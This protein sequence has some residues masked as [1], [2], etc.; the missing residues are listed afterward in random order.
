MI[1]AWSCI[2]ALC[3]D[4]VLETSKLLERTTFCQA[5][6]WRRCV[7]TSQ[8][9]TDFVGHHLNGWSDQ[10]ETGRRKGNFYSWTHLSPESTKPS[11]IFQRCV[12]VFFG[13]SMTHLWTVSFLQDVCLRSLWR[14][15]GLPPFEYLISFVFVIIP[16]S[17][18][19]Q[20][21]PVENLLSNWMTLWSRC[22]L[23]WN[24]VKL[25]VNIC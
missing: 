11:N 2:N 16:L 18:K 25:C 15:S 24:Y 7:A 3:D 17:F 19:S 13:K 22:N 6:R 10:G 9:R 1:D 21:H 4:H 12:W 20:S 8:L 14:C 5:W 23:W